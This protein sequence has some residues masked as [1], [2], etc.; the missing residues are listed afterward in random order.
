M[1]EHKRTGDTNR[2]EQNRTEK[3]NRYTR[4]LKEKS[5]HVV[6]LDGCGN[7]REALTH[8][9]IQ[10]P[11]EVGWREK[12]YSVQIQ[13][14]IEAKIAGILT[15]GFWKSLL[16]KRSIVCIYTCPYL[17]K[18]TPFRHGKLHSGA[19]PHVQ[20]EA[21]LDPGSF[22]HITPSSPSYPWD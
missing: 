5:I 2:T 6:E 10:G 19:Q 20:A 21:P 16:W 1:A 12:L 7:E 17:S 14:R 3:Q 15:L 18:H 11:T 13:A 22:S 9:E 8:N 4:P